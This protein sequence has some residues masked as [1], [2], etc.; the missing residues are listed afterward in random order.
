MSVEYKVRI[1]AIPLEDPDGYH[2]SVDGSRFQWF[3]THFKSEDE[4][5]KY[6]KDSNKKFRYIG[7][8]QFYRI[9]ETMLK[10]Y[11]D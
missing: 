1:F 9:E 10:E 5:N 11:H 6:Y 2:S 8:K 4:A 3:T 7:A